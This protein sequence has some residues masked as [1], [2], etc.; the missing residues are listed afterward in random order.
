[1]DQN[2][3][4][5]DLSSKGRQIPDLCK[6][7]LIVHEITSYSEL[8]NIEYNMNIVLELCFRKD[9]RV[10]IMSMYHCFPLMLYQNN[11]EGS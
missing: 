6:D 10:I 11:N 1:M 5:C 4:R 8:K 2:V 7:Y 9:M 3:L